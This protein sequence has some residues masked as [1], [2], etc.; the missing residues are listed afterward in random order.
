MIIRHDNPNVFFFETAYIVIFYA[1][2]EYDIKWIL[3][4]RPR[5]KKPMNKH[6]QNV[7]KLTNICM[8]LYIKAISDHIHCNCQKNK[9][10]IL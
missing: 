2:D 7:H 10:R 4:H 8:S 9:L 6:N 3:K 5:K 1:T